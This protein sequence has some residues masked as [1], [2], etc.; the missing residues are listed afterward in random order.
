[1]CVPACGVLKLSN[2]L[3]IP[4]IYPLQLT[5]L[6]PCT[7]LTEMELG[8]RPYTIGAP[9]ALGTSPNTL[10]VNTFSTRSKRVPSGT[11][12]AFTVISPTPAI[13]G[14]HD[15]TTWSLRWLMRWVVATAGI[16]YKRVERLQQKRRG[17]GSDCTWWQENASRQWVYKMREEVIREE[18]EQWEWLHLVRHKRTLVR[19]RGH[20]ALRR[21]P[22]GSHRRHTRT[23]RT[24]V[25][26]R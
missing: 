17:N 8:E 6:A 5:L 14:V 12:V 16:V 4:W 3:K 13:G 23:Q 22:H 21:H 18:K 15:S 19:V 11:T 25:W 1:M 2:S 10:C 20:P 7:Q 9:S 26:R 24:P